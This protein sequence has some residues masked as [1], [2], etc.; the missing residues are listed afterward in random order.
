VFTGA[1][2]GSPVNIFGAK[3]QTAGIT[4]VS[5][6]K[7]TGDFNILD[8][9]AYTTGITITGTDAD[10]DDSLVGGSG[11][12]TLNTGKDG[13]KKLK[14]NGGNDT[15]NV[16][17]EK[18]VTV[19]D[20]S[21]ADI[22]K[23]A[24][25]NTA[26]VTA[27]VTADY[28]ASSASTND[29]SV[30]GA[31]INGTK[32]AKITLTAAGNTFGYTVTGQAANSDGKGSSIVG[33]AKADAILGGTG[34]GAD[35]IAGGSGNDT[36]TG[37]GGIDNLAGDTGNDTFVFTTDLA[38]TDTINGGVGNDSI[39]ITSTGNV[40]A[41]VDF[42]TVSNLTD[43][44]TTGTD[45]VGLTISD[46]A[47]TTA[48][49]IT[50]A[51]GA[52]AFTMTNSADSTSTKFNITGGAAA[53]SLGGSNADDTIASANGADTITGG[54]GNDSITLTEGIA[55]TDDLIFNTAATNGIDTIIGFTSTGDDLDFGLQAAATAFHSATVAFST[56]IA[57][58]TAGTDNDNV[59]I[60]DVDVAALQFANAAALV[61]GDTGSIGSSIEGAD[62]QAVV[63]YGSAA[64]P[65]ESRVAIATIA[66]AG[67]ITAA[68]DV[69]ILKAIKS[70][71]A[72][73]NA[74]D[75]ILS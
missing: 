6:K 22:L 32:N 5:F 39:S 29:L 19:E 56:I 41:V 75:F 40:T 23:I 54:A 60:L 72:S 71:A 28:T 63:I 36:I 24:S 58:N 18:A 43:I 34:S 13:E 27:T 69:A 55:A 7:A 74:A 37:K 42:D 35:T 33:S 12:D 3:A 70:E 49:T 30:A 45:T 52:G 11:A 44:V 73:F 64:A 10:D 67:G 21:G 26:G 62:T 53:D 57:T 68:T 20:L 51:S 9:T 17:S 2:G 16:T 61:S 66:N 65:G 47:E 50:I 4:S 38:A 31:K 25:S 46:I 14:G 1:N 8:A 48:Q 59:V 15:F